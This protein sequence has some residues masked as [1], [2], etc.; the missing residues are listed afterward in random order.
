MKQDDLGQG[1]ANP[2]LE[3]EIQAGFLS[4]RGGSISL[5]DI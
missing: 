5:G 2:V 4:Y 1:W 3:G